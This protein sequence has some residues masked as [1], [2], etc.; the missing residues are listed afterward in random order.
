VHREHLPA[1]AN[2]GIKLRALR[3][4]RDGVAR[5]QHV[6]PVRQVPRRQDKDRVL[7]ENPRLGLG[8]VR[9]PDEAA[10]FADTF[11]RH[12]R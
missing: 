6:T 7:L 10:A 12:R 5:C 4:R 3:Y 11:A 1:A 2:E 9:R 8:E